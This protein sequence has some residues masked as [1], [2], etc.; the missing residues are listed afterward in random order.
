MQSRYRDT[1]L[2]VTYKWDEANSGPANSKDEHTFIHSRNVDSC[3]RTAR[4]QSAQ[5]AVRPRAGNA[6]AL[7]SSGYENDHHTPQGELARLAQTR[8]YGWKLVRM[9]DLTG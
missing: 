6:V 2:L 3:G 5:H 8:I 4:L 7:L 1:H 9:L